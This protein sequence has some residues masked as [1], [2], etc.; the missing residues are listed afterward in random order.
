MEKTLMDET[1]EVDSW[2]MKPEDLLQTYATKT[3][4]ISEISDDTLDANV[5]SVEAPEILPAEPTP[6]LAAMTQPALAKRF[7]GRESFMAP[8][9]VMMERDVYYVIPANALTYPNPETYALSEVYDNEK[10]QG[11]LFSGQ[12]RKARRAAEKQA[13]KKAKKTTK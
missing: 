9:G 8:S 13:E 10:P 3:E 4:E 12:N 5:E 6:G 1:M 11:R 7:K 2:T